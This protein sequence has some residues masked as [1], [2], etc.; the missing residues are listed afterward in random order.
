MDLIPEYASF[1]KPW[2]NTCK[3]DVVF[4]LGGDGTILHLLNNLYKNYSQE[5][6]PKIAAF[7]LGSLGY[8]CHFDDKEHHEVIESVVFNHLKI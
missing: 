1:F 4:T 3:L 2:S 6:V 5:E 7:R 8:L